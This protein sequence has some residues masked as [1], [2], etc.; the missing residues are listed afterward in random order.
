M[1]DPASA[2]WETAFAKV[3]PLNLR[4]ARD[5]D[6]AVRRAR[7]LLRK[8]RDEIATVD[9]RGAAPSERRAFE[10][11]LGHLEAGYTDEARGSA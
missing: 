1:P 8:M 11:L 7:Y 3:P 5:D 9:I 2:P 10:L 6:P 4:E